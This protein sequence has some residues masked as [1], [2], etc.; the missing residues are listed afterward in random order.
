[1]FLVLYIFNI[2]K[3]A[4]L[5]YSISTSKSKLAKINASNELL[6]ESEQ[7]SVE[8]LLSLAKDKNMVEVKNY[9]TFFQEAG[10]ALDR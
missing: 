7:V 2:N 9:D 8:T 10:V 4:V 5:E 3:I 1:M 6:A